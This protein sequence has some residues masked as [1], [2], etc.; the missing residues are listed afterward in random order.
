MCM[1][2]PCF[3]IFQK[4]I[5][6]SSTVN[7]GKRKKTFPFPKILTSSPPSPKTHCPATEL[8]GGVLLFSLLSSTQTL[9]NPA[10]FLLFKNP[11]FPYLFPPQILYSYFCHPLRLL[12]SLLVFHLPFSSKSCYQIIKLTLIN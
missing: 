9:L 6:S 10:F 11:P 4:P 8:Q 12:P 2:L 7:R 1:T 3:L 5:P